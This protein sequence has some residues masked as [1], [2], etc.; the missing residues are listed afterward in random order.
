MVENNGFIL[1][2]QFSFSLRHSTREQ[3]HQIVQINEALENEQYCSTAFLDISQA[4]S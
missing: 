1:N 2:H 3:T 4:F